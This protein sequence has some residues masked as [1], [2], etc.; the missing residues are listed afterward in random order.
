MLNALET[1]DLVYEAMAVQAITA[2]MRL[3][4]D[5][6]TCAQLVCIRSGRDKDSNSPAP[7]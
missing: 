3:K 5:S 7:W 1:V 6:A 2:S 4:A